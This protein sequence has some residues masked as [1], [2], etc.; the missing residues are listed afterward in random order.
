MTTASAASR[1]A[2]AV[3]LPDGLPGFEQCRTFVVMSAPD[4]APLT[5]LQG[6]DGSQP[7]FLALDPRLV[8][9]DYDASL[10]PA[11]RQ[12]LGAAPDDPLLWL[13]LVGLDGQRLFVNLRAPV[14]INP[15]RMLGLQVVAADSPY[16][17]QHE[18]LLG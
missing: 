17:T 5:R 13:A 8:L 1:P 14:V 3:T 11:D 12:R 6:L 18:L 7:T 4:L 15:A 9:P 2:D 16:S 10:S